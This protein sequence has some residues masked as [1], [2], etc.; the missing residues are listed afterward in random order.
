LASSWT[1][2]KTVMKVLDIS[3]NHTRDISQENPEKH[4]THVKMVAQPDNFPKAPQNM[5]KTQREAYADYYRKKLEEFRADKSNGMNAILFDEYRRRFQNVLE[6]V[7]RAVHAHHGIKCYDDGNSMNT[8]LGNVFYLHV[9][10]VINIYVNRRRGVPTHV[11]IPTNLL[12]E[13]SDELV[14]VL[15]SEMLTG[16]EL[17]TFDYQ[18]NIFYQCFCYYGN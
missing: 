1:L 11:Y 6:I 10:D 2:Q 16:E 15:T 9:C 4:D 3:L 5:Y 8:N 18:C 14:D 7:N 17:E 12:N 13:I